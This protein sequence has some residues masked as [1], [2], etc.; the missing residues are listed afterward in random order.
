[1]RVARD[2][3]IASFTWCFVENV[4]ADG[5]EVF[6]LRIGLGCVDSSLI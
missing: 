2:W 6:E 3:R 1:M 5:K 4:S